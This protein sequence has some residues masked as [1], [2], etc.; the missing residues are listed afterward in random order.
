[1]IMM[2]VMVIQNYDDDID[3][4]LFVIIRILQQSVV[5][6]NFLC[7]VGMRCLW[8]VVYLTA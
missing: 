6:V 8:W 1:M 5:L 4:E 3:D 7:V 2:L